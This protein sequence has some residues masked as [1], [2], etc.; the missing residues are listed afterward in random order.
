[1]I[2]ADVSKRKIG[3]NF[4]K[5]NEA[6][7]LVWAPLA[8]TVEVKLATSDRTIRLSKLEHGYWHNVTHEIKEGDR[9]KFLID[10]TRELPDPA[11]LHQPEGVHGYSSA[12]NITTFSW[13]DEQWSNIPLAEYIFYELHT[14]TYTESGDFKGIE[15]KLKYLK[16]LGVNAIEIMPVSQFPGT[17]NWGYD[18]VYPFAV[19]H[20]YGGAEGLMQLVNLCHEHGI[21]V[22]L[23]VVYNHMGPEGN[24]LGEYGPY[25]TEKYKTPWGG[26]LNFDDGWCDGVRH[27]FIENALMWFRD[28]H[29]DAL[30]LDAVHA[31]KD[32]SAVHILEEIRLRV[33]ELMKENG[34]VHY[35]IVELDLNDTRFIKPKNEGGLGMDGQWMDEFHHAL[36]VTAG[37]E[38]NGYYSDFNGL[39]HLAKS[40]ADAY[41][42]DGQYSPHRKKTFGVKAENRPGEQFVVFS[43]NHDHVGNR[44]LGERTS[45][46]VSFEMLKLLAG[47]VLVSPFL[48]MLFMGEEWGEPNP[49]LYFVSHTD[50]EL[51]DAVRNGRKKEFAAFHAIGEA[52]DP[53]AE[54]TFNESKL[55]WDLLDKGPHHLLLDY[56]K[57]LISLRKNCSALKIPDRKNITVTT[58]PAQKTLVVKR[59]KEQDQVFIFMNFSN[60]QQIIALASEMHNW[61]KIFDSADP[62]WGGPVPK[63]EMIVHPGSIAIQPESVQIYLNNNV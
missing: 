4:N 1:M 18:G 15:K 41:V 34:R 8:D 57:A 48:P 55:T 12:L 43:Q 46:L 40:F 10:G 49:F 16:N 19:Q 35:L 52:P 26:A 27:F 32:F 20:S 9:Y 5:N 21:A 50:P 24:Y 11:S 47:A 53:M 13:A 56:Y 30:R 36:R 54:Q 3:I 37:G 39:E 28:F 60:K 62:N 6:E 22:V 7:V 25:F 2:V 31:I 45:K 42:Y 17:R 33:D 61:N 23:D 38:R 29:I 58:H 14:G 51:A 44:M 63:Q 59:W